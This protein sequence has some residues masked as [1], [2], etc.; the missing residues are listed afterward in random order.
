[1]DVESV[2]DEKYF[3]YKLIGDSYYIEEN[4]H[5]ALQYYL[6][7]IEF[8]YT[9]HQVQ[10]LLGEMGIAINAC[11]IEATGKFD[12]PW[13]YVGN[14]NNGGTYCAITNNNPNYTLEFVYEL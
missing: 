9:N 7:A 3:I 10:K 2:Y 4:Y 8:I 5:D 13:I 11:E 1:M 12:S 6:K 14:L